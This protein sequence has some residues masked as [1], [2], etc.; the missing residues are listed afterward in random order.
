MTVLASYEPSAQSF[1]SSHLSTLFALGLLK[2][3][4]WSTSIRRRIISAFDIEGVISATKIGVFGVE[5]CLL[6]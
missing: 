1:T 2:P 3:A 6:I 4:C 5:G